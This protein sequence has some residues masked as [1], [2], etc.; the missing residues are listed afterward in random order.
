MGTK[1]G[2]LNIKDSESINTSFPRFINE[3]NKIGGEFFEKNNYY[4]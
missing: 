2:P 1:L 4:C 3:L